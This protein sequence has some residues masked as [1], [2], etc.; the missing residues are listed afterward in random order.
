MRLPRDLHG[1]PSMP[2]YEY[3]C[4]DCGNR[5]VESMSIDDHDKRKLQCPSC[6]SQNTD[7]VIEAPYVKAAKKS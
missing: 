5:F 2:V 3:E 7:S 6:K 4:R 1:G